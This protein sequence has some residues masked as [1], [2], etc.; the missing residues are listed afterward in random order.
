MHDGA[1]LVIG[2]GLNVNMQKTNSDEIS[3]AWCSL[4]QLLHHPVDRNQL[5]ANLIDKI[6]EYL[7]AFEHSGF[8]SF[9]LLWEKYDMTFGNKIQVDQ[10]GRK[11]QGKACGIDE[12]GRLKIQLLD[13]Q[14]IV[15]NSGDVAC[16]KD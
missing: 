5:A 2:V 13:G 1:S 7:E 12:Q 8:P 11:I 3:Q 6:I 16:V 4:A 10:G 9:K 14:L 15:I